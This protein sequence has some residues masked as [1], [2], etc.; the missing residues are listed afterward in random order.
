M[1]HIAELIDTVSY[2]LHQ[3]TEPPTESAL[4][5]Y[6]EAQAAVLQMKP[7]LKDV[8]SFSADEINKVVR[9]LQTRFSIRMNLGTLFESEHY[10]PWLHKKR[11][12]INW[13][14]WERYK[15]HLLMSKGFSPHVVRS[16]DEITDDVLDHLEDPTKEGGW[17][18]RGLVV[19]HVQSGKTAN[20]TGLV[21][22]AAD[23]GYKV[24]IVL[25]G[26]LNSLRNQTQERIDSDFIGWCTRNKEHIGS[27]KHGNERM[28]FYLT[29]S[30]EDFKRTTARAVGMKLGALKEPVVLILK[31]NKSTLE[32][33]YEWLCEHNNN[34]LKAF[35]MLLVD[36]EA[37]HASINTN[38]E[39][40]DP[41]A[42]NW[43][44][45]N[46]LSIFERNSFVGYT[47]TPF[48]NIFIDPDSEHEMENG[49]AYKDL[50]PKDFI[51]SL[52]PP[53]NYIGPHRIFTEDADLNI[54]HEI[55]DNEI[56][57]NLPLKHKKDFVPTK[58]PE[59]LKYAIRCFVIAK[60]IRIL[61][62]QINKHHSMMVN[63]SRFTAVQNI[64]KGLIVDYVQELMSAI[65][66]F[67]GLKEE[68]A[69]ENNNLKE[70]KT[71]WEIEFIGAEYGWSDIQKTLKISIGPVKVISVNVSSSASDSIDYSSK[72]FPEGVSI[73]AVGGL[74]LSRGLTLE[75]LITSYFLR[76][77]IMYDTLMQMGRWFGYRDGYEDICR[78][79]MPSEAVAW[80]SHIA[81]ATEELRADFVAMKKARLTPIEFGLRVRCHPTSL[82]VTARNKM[83]TGKN[84]PHRISL[85]GRLIESVVISPEPTDIEHNLKLVNSTIEKA[86]SVKG[87]ERV[88]N[89]GYVWED[90]PLHIIQE[91][92]HEFQNHPLSI[93]TYHSEPLIQHLNLLIQDGI[94]TGDIL[95]KTLKKGKDD[96]TLP[97]LTLKGTMQTRT[98]KTADMSDTAISF[99]RKSRIG[100]ARDEEI[101][102]SNEII[103]KLHASHNGRTINPKIYREIEG[104]KPLLIIHLLNLEVDDK[105]HKDFPKTVVAYGLS[106]P[107][108]ATS[109]KP[110]RLVEYIVNIPFWKQ[111]F[112]DVFEEDEVNE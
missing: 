69:L 107:G 28:P 23:A 108:C 90:I 61:R 19:G 32:N 79:F 56:D 8:V 47:A 73:I 21:C 48:A 13:Y 17:S 15:K 104:K 51:L 96:S 67:S 101:G 7:G 1:N 50:F 16:L 94:T 112:E 45:R 38:K 64:L 110:Q 83:R 36:D 10:K 97:G 93:Y 37:D 5:K 92:V 71:T 3:L 68:Q 25:T 30:V 6:V 44:I 27:S 20:Y 62:G 26:M 88:D 75:G 11:G 84:V 49:E 66:N 95:L 80:Y 57:E 72:N 55:K 4:K 109:R 59:S 58:L 91:F 41:G 9:E 100:E 40:K 34:N 63:V 103:N 78:I 14:Y 89:R 111:N 35:P 98:S 42:I 82:I 81:N 70:L 18:R 33:L 54:L 74:S 87:P 86:T 52:D 39:D 31:K 53:D 85:E 24:I 106:F 46:L 77:S 29:T 43:S 2:S 60:S 22:K 102:I 12:E 65:N 99:K 105:V 76:N